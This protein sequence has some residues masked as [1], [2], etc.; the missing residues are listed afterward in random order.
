MKHAALCALL[1][2]SCQSKKRQAKTRQAQGSAVANMS[3]ASSAASPSQSPRAPLP[4]LPDPLPGQRTD[5][6]PRVG[7]AIRV[8][9]G[10]FDGDHDRELVVVDAK[11]LRIV[12]TGGREVAATPIAAGIQVLVA[13][14]IDGDGRDE[15]LTGWG[16]SREHMDA[17][18]RISLYRFQRG[19]L[20]EEVIAEP[21]AERN[22]V[23]A[24]L[25]LADRLFVAYFDSKYMV[26]SA[27]A[28]RGAQGWQVDPI[29]SVRMATSYAHGDLDGDGKPDLIVG[30]IYGDDKGIDGDAFLLAADG[31]RKP[32]PTTRGLRS[33]ALVGSDLFIGDGWHQNYGEHG[34]GLLTWVRGGSSALR[35]ELIEDTPGQFGIDRILPASI[36][37]GA[38]LVTQ[39]SHY[40]RVYVRRGETWRGLTIGGAVR[41]VAV[42]DL[43]GKP[44]DEIVLLGDKSEIVKLEAT[45]W[46]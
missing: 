37:G 9:V 6:T 3:T 33:L 15:I 40:V 5:I 4:P 22:E 38:A 36:G 29:A 25:P 11:Q 12:E 32:I 23:V 42:G 45:A 41:D 17:K 16:Q 10:D 44:G 2:V 24:I 34:R 14:D 21:Q 27:Y 13:R 43:D 39:G 1:L 19:K 7:S 8:A 26:T 20:V 31:T 30:R 35:S 28:K 46:P 18:S